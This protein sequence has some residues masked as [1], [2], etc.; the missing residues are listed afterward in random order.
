MGYARVLSVGLVG[1]TGSLVEVEADLS[2]GLP[3]LSMSGLPD[4]VLQEARDRIRAAVIN[5]GV[6]WPNRRITLNLLPA[7]LPKHGSVFDLA[8]AAAVL[9]AAGLVP[10]RS[11]DTVVLLGELGLDGRARPVRGILPAVLA[12]ARA[13]IG[14]VIVPADNAQEAALVPGMSVGA[15]ATLGALLDFLRG[16][17][18]LPG[19][20]PLPEVADR[21]PGGDLCEVV[22]QERG[23]RAVEIAAAGG[24][25][26]AFFGPPGAGKTMLAERMPSILPALDDDAALEVTAVHSVAGVLPAGAALIRRPPYRAPHHTSTAAAIVGGGNG[27]PRPG[28]VSLAH[29]GILFLDEAPEFRPA[30]LNALREPLEN[31]TIQ[32]ARAAGC[33]SYPASVQLVLAANPCPCGER[34]GRCECTPNQRRRYLGRLSGPLLD[35][36]D[37]QIDLLPVRSAHLVVDVAPPEP[38][39][40]VARR[41][42]A[43]RHTAA[44]RWSGGGGGLNAR[45]PGSLLRSPRWRLPRETT[46]VVER[47]VDL[48]SLSARGH[49]RILRVAWTIADLAGRAAPDPGDLAEAIELRT[50]TMP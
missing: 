50:R 29:R 4:A 26:L 6:D 25:N 21:P 40:V 39:T 45:V 9:C 23:R 13:G 35:R 30:V 37:L 38:S 22:G 18:A 36:V 10:G 1:L 33:M 49:D 3:G 19:P 34:G 43:A 2:V 8:M 17:T 7:S 24:H 5:S 42:A 32:L 12:A 20:A 11:L 41:V 44:G 15:V 16:G 27:L 28:A 47:L 31:G 46:R 48:G 14:H